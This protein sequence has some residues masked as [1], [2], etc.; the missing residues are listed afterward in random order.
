MPIYLDTKQAD[1][2]SAFKDVIN[3]DRNKVHDVSHIVQNIIKDVRQNGNQA[4]IKYTRQFDDPKAHLDQIMM[5]SK[6]LDQSV[7]LLSSDLKSAMQLAC[8]RIRAF[9]EKQKP[10]D[11]SYYDDTNTLLGMRYTPIDRVGVYI[12]GGA[13]SYPSSVLM[14]VIPAQVAG[15]QDIVAT[16]PCPNGVISPAVL[17]AFHMLGI[18]TIYKIGGAQAVAALAY[19]TETIQSVDKITGPGNAFVA[20]AK[21]QIYGRCGIDSIAGPSEIL[22]I[23]DKTANVD[24]VIIDLLAQAE[25][26]PTAQSILMTSSPQLAQQ[27][28][29]NIYIQIEKLSRKDIARQ[30]WD[31]HG[32]IIEC[33]DLEQAADL[34]NCLAP[35]HLELCVQDPHN[36]MKYIRHA[37]SIF[38]GHYTPEAIGDYLGGPNHVLPTDRTARFSSGL[39]VIDFMKRTTFIECTQKGLKEIGPSVMDFADSEGLEAHKLSVQKRL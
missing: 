5:T 27:V 16:V 35:E 11:F 19:G 32:V 14:N 36:L 1:F 7:S 20:E 26:D 13:A 30:S 23:A 33:N 15:V 8:K 24:H 38:M 2:L 25:H 3:H 18:D 10:Q 28:R 12:P 9:H 22:I 4:V 34:S 31:N 6:E 21:R 17:Y 37:G 39:G 29:D